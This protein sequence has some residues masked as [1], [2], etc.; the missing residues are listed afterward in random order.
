MFLGRNSRHIGGGREMTPCGHEESRP[1]SF[2]AW[3]EGKQRVY[4]SVSQCKECSRKI[5]TQTR[6]L[7]TDR[8][9]YVGLAKGGSR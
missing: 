7:G 1:V 4:E 3:R 8:F 9:T 2:R 5:V 6:T